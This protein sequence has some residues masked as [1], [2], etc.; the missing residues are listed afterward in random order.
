MHLYRATEQDVGKRAD[1]FIV[2]QLDD[3]SR[4]SLSGLFEKGLVLVNGK[5]TRASQKLHRGDKVKVDTRLLKTQPGPIELPILYENDDVLVLNKPAGILTHSKGALNTE[6]TVATWLLDYLKKA[7]YNIKPS[8]SGCHPENRFGIVH[9]LDR[10]TSG[11]MICAKND[12]TLKWLQKQFSTRKVRKIYHAVVEGVLE[13][14]EAIIDAPLQRNPQKPQTFHVSAGGR[15]AQTHYKT[16]KSIGL[17]PMLSLVE[18]EPKT[19]RTHQLRVHL[20]YIGH[21]IVG[22]KV[23]G[24]ALSSKKSTSF[25]RGDRQMYL[26][27]KSL[28][29]NLPDGKTSKFEAP[30]PKYFRDPF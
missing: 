2:E 9:R 11:V 21:P 5:P 1:I 25:R 4:S 17:H 23:Y 13:P 16:L 24:H 28:E 15:P 6:A 29:I 3:F 26:H 10:Q 30:E 8:F 7:N 14:A 19:G 20:K 18:L 22:D 12:K 27:A